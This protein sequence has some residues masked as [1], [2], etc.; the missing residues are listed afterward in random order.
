MT[1]PPSALGR[2]IYVQGVVVKMK[3]DSSASTVR[4][5]E[6]RPLSREGFALS[7]RRASSSSSLFFVVVGL[8]FALGLQPAQAQVGVCND[9]IDNDGDGR[10]DFP[11]DLGCLGAGDISEVSDRDQ[12]GITDLSDIC[13]EAA[14]P[15]QRDTDGDGYGDACDPDQDND[16]VP[17]ASDDCPLAANAGSQG[18]D[19]DGD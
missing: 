19:S 4:F 7:R 2:M 3:I 9:G 15:S 11:V 8:L 13:I 17:N 5:P 10:T 12:D 18:L 6:L 16:G 14:D 1:R